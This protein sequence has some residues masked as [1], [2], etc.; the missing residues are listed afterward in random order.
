MGRIKRL[1]CIASAILALATML[2]SDLFA[3]NT[4]GQ[5]TRTG[6]HTYRHTTTGTHKRTSMHRRTTRTSMHR[7]TGTRTSMHRRTGTRT[8]MRTRTR[9]HITTSGRVPGV[10]LTSAQQR[11]VA[12]IR[13]ET[14]AQEQAERRNTSY[15]RA[16]REQRAMAARR[17]GHNRVIA[18]LT[19]EQRAQHTTYYNNRMQRVATRYG[20]PRQE[21]IP[22]VQLSS[23][24]E[25]S[26]ARIRQ[27][28]RQR[29]N[30]IDRDTRLSRAERDRRIAAIQQ[31]EHNRV[32]STLTPEQRTQ[33]ETAW[34]N[35][36]EMLGR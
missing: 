19:P 5:Y 7:R 25:Q 28:T 33:F 17:A 24:Q 18:V 15:A 31:E 29:M 9:R 16:E 1:L 21:R 26:V 22:G 13:R 3:R 34:Q 35:R 6:T 20:M 10:R 23:A 36:P 14:R 11:R 8:A 12:Q 2:T 32:I 27:D 4:R 30:A